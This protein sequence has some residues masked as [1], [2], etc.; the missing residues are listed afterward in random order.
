MNELPI[1]LGSIASGIAFIYLNILFIYVL[2]NAFEKSLIWGIGIVCFPLLAVIY[3]ITNWEN[4]KIE[5]RDSAITLSLLTG[6]GL[7]VIAASILIK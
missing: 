3:T 4:A 6:F 2:L 5:F 7:F 1:A